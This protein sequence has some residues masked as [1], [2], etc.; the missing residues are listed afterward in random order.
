[1]CFFEK[2][3]IEK[4]LNILLGY[5]LSTVKFNTK[6]ICNCCLTESFYVKNKEENHF[7]PSKTFQEKFIFQVSKTKPVCWE[8]PFKRVENELM[9]FIKYVLNCLED[10]DT[11]FDEILKPPQFKNFF[12]TEVFISLA[13]SFIHDYGKDQLHEWTVWFLMHHDVLDNLMYQAYT[14]YVFFM[15]T[16]TITRKKFSESSFDYTPNPLCLRRMLYDSIMKIEDKEIRK[17]LLMEYNETD[18][19]I[20]SF[21]EVMHQE[22]RIMIRRNIEFLITENMDLD[23]TSLQVVGSLKQLITL[24]LVSFAQ[25]IAG[26]F[27]G[28]RISI[29]DSS[30]KNYMIQDFE[31]LNTSYIDFIWKFLEE[32]LWKMEMSIG[33]KKPYSKKFDTIAVLGV[34]S[35][36][37]PGLPFKIE[38]SLMKK[39]VSFYLVNGILESTSSK[40][41]I[42]EYENVSSNKKCA[43]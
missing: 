35:I 43:T 8:I 10:S 39:K 26:F 29:E 14:Y 2:N 21:I 18:E 19:S 24:G 37:W 38:R 25:F 20:L 22:V 9:Y 3:K 27:M 31:I 1:M 4:T 12:G 5:S 33:G 17:N 11:S 7:K 13:F 28:M 30:I 32:I 40:R 6:S 16:R 34:P 36:L 23:K 41:S 15:L 42:E